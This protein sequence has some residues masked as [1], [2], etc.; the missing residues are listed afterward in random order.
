MICFSCRYFKS[1]GLLQKPYE[2]TEV[3]LEKTSDVK[4]TKFPE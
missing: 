2:V 1:D 4:K 3:I